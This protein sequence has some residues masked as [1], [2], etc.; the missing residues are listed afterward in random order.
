VSSAFKS[1]G[2]FTSES[3]QADWKA[4]KIAELMRVVGEASE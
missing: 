2:G 4:E 1:V 3:L